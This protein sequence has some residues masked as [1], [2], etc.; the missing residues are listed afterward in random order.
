MSDCVQ[1]LNEASK[2]PK[3]IIHKNGYKL[4]FTLIK[5]NVLYKPK[6]AVFTKKPLKYIEKPVG[7]STCV[8]VIQ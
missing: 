6:I 5:D 2:N 7:A 1:N 8:L 3:T 4:N